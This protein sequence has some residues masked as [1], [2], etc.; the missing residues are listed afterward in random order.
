MSVAQQLHLED[1]WGQQAMSTPMLVGSGAVAVR[2]HSM[3]AYGRSMLDEFRE[4]LVVPPAPPQ[5]EERA[6]IIEPD[7]SRALNKY[8]RQGWRVKTTQSGAENA[9]LVIVE[10]ELFGEDD[11][12]D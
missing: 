3:D 7:S 1:D 4:S 11:L 9:F 10:R 8:L 12:C 5:M 2:P 6:V